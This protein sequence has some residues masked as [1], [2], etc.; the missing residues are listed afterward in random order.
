MY[1]FK[2]HKIYVC[3]N[4][5]GIYIHSRAAYNPCQSAELVATVFS[6]LIL[7]RAQLS[8]R[9]S[10]YFPIEI[11]YKYRSENLIRK[12]YKVG[13]VFFR[14]VLDFFAGITTACR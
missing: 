14:V 7:T 13:L 4:D 5:L 6:L 8:S 3:T 9:F 11:K 10:R 1:E 2:G 12:V